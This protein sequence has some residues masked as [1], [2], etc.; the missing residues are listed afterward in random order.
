MISELGLMIDGSI[1]HATHH[2][3]HLIDE[4]RAFRLARSAK[5]RN[6]HRHP[7]LRRWA[8][9]GTTTTGPGPA[10]QAA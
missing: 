7:S 8:R 3:Q 9:V 1:S 6:A 10:G 5:K 2:K 4:A